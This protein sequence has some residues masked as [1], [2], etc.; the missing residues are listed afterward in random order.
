[1]KLMCILFTS[2]T[3]KEFAKHQEVAKKL[4]ADFFFA[5]PYHSWERGL[6][7]NTNGLV[8]QYFPKK[9]DFAKLTQ[10]DVDKVEYLLNTRPRKTLNYMTPLE[11][12]FEAT[13]RNLSYA[14]RG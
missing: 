10:R 14:L 1:M 6:N 2:D 5:R 3:G 7:E 4:N 8:R 12:F 9:T 11:V 13:G